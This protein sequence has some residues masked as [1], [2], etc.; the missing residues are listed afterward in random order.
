MNRSIPERGPF[1][2]PRSASTVSI[3]SGAGCAVTGPVRPVGDQIGVEGQQLLD[4]AVHVVTV[5]E[6]MVDVER[7]MRLPVA[8]EQPQMH[9]RLAL[10]EMRR[11]VVGLRRVDL[12]DL[13]SRVHQ[14]VGDELVT[15]V[16]AA[17]EARGE[18][19]MRLEQ[20]VKGVRQRVDIDRTLEVRGETHEVVRLGEHFLAERQLANDR[21]WKH[22]CLSSLV[23]IYD[24]STSSI[25]SLP[26]SISSSRE[27]FPDQLQQCP[28]EPVG[29]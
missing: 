25:S 3:D 2:M 20:Q 17:L 24:R 4:Q 10:V 7:R 27:R 18:H 28:G 22:G 11:R 14:V 19:R 1:W 23:E 13:E 16:G 12:D 15:A 5:G 6:R 8:D 9:Q 26:E 29:K 21:R